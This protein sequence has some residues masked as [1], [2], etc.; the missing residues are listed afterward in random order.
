MDNKIYSNIEEAIN[1]IKKDCRTKFDSTIEL[2][3]NL[4]LDVKKSDQMIR[5]NLVLPN[6]TGKSMKVAV[7]ASQ[8]SDLADLNLK[9]EDL[10]SILNGKLRAGVDFDVLVTEPGYMPKIAKVAR[11]LGPA[12]IM[13]NPKSGTVTNDIK[14]AV[15][16]IKKGKVEVRTEQN[17]PIIHT[18]IGKCSFETSN[19]V[20]NLHEIMTNLRISKPAKAKPGWVVSI[21]LSPTMG[22]SYQLDTKIFNF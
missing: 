12:G 14:K 7:L 3:I 20:E 6:G 10:D 15:E 13:P 2:H 11:I 22:T 18:I 16:Q 21:F 8:N 17:F 9:E 1:D 5:Y 19:L 4:N